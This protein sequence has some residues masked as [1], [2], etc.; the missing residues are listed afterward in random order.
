MPQHE[1][2]VASL[3][4]GGTADVV[5]RPGKPG[6]PGAPELTKKVCHS[7]TDGSTVRIEALN[8]AGAA[9]GDWICLSRSSGMVVKNAAVLLGIPALG[10]ISGLVGGTIITGGLVVNVT[11]TIVSAALGL[12]L[13]IIIGTATYRR[14]SAG[15]QPVIDRVIMTR[16]E[17]AS[18]PCGN[19][20]HFQNQDN[21][22]DRC[23]L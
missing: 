6:I 20:S 8:S 1:G 23:G 14:V 17:V 7:P 18:Q 2:L 5:I 11:G 19:Q 10:A 3:G 22:C 9:V 12:L 16:T 21:P 13:G 4:P 15:N